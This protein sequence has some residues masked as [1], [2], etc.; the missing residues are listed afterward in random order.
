MTLDRLDMP[1]MEV[2]NT[3][4]GQTITAQAGDR[5]VDIELDHLTATA[6]RMRVV[7]K[8]NILIR[9]RATATE[10]ILQ[11]DRT[12]SDHPHLARGDVKPAR[13]LR[14]RSSA[15]SKEASH[16]DAYRSRARH[17]LSR[18]G[19]RTRPD[20]NHDRY[21]NDDRRH[22]HRDD[23]R[24]NHHRHDNHGHA[25]QWSDVRT[26]LSRE[27]EDRAGSLRCPEG[28]NHD[29]DH[30]VDLGNDDE[31]D[32]HHADSRERPDAAHARSDRTDET[33]WPG[34]GE[35]LSRDAG[36]RPRRRQEPRKRRERVQQAPPEHSLHGRKL[37]R[38]YERD[39][40]DVVGDWDHDQRR[41]Q[42]G[43]EFDE[44]W[45]GGLR[46]GW[47]QVIGLRDVDG[48]GW[49]RRPAGPFE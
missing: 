14:A 4:K 29:D 1:V 36:A 45:P 39:D 19:A 3:D 9:D 13:P 31:L 5:S 46:K 8:K 6:S 49:I 35:R 17:F 25:S 24:W 42:G 37:E 2:E 47:L 40:D 15:A 10:I 20:R 23:D 7:V 11:T 26:A 21:R 27:S 16:A 41:R 38:H 32:V 28:S 30:C 12:L 33:G 43:R 18:R 34:V 44:F 22:D 48:V